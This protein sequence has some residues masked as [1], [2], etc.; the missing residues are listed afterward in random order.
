[1]KRSI[2][3]ILVLLSV[4]PLIRAQDPTAGVDSYRD[5]FHYY[6]Q[7]V[8]I[9]EGS[10]YYDGSPYL[11]EDFTEADIIALNGSSYEKVR[12]NYDILEDRFVYNYNDTTYVLGSLN[13]I[14]WI[15]IGDREFAYKTFNL[16]NTATT[17]FLELISKGRYNIWKRYNM[18]FLERR[19]DIPYAEVQ[20]ATFREEFPD[21]FIQLGENNIIKFSS[22]K[23]ISK[24]LKDKQIKSYIRDNKLK[25]RREEDI[26]TLA[27]YLNGR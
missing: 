26:L 14:G 22:L 3:F 17:G 16:G 23:K 8:Y 11:F 20:N 24:L 5:F 9:N 13:L 6:R 19:N 27:S 12:M 4:N 7:Q 1:M 2:L 10:S 15:I 18:T 21:Y 25:M